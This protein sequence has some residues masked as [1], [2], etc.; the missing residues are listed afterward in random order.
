MLPLL[1]G[2]QW[3]YCDAGILDRTHLRF[4]GQ[5]SARELIEQAGLELTAEASTGH[6]PGDGDYW[7]NVITLGLLS[8]LFTWQ[9][10][11]RGTRA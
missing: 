7:K 11:L 1:F 9:F 10:L 2:G 4:F 8:N 6:R 3:K 5:S